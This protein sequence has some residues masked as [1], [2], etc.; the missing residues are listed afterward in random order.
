MYSSVQRL[1]TLS[2][3][4]INALFFLCLW[5]TVSTYFD[6]KYAASS[7]NLISAQRKTAR[8]SYSFRNIIQEYAFVRFELDTDITPLFHW[9]TKQVLIYVV[10][11]YPY[12]EVILWTRT[13]RHKKDAVIHVRNQQNVYSFNDIEGS[14]VNKNLTLSMY[15]NIM[16]H[17]GI[18][19]WGNGS[20][21]G[22]LPFSVS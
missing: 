17:V 3:L 10:A 11:S 12:N 14:F 16:P 1:N 18:L 22:R 9:N 19:K 20:P 13:V 15:Y 8:I 6:K 7:V 2:S 4:W 21:S 5:I